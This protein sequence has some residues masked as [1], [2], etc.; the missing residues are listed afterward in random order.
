VS[1]KNAWILKRR[2][3]KNS[4]VRKVAIK[5]FKRIVSAVVNK[6]LQ[7]AKNR[8]KAK[9]SEDRQEAPS[10]ARPKKIDGI[11]VTPAIT[12]GNIV[13]EIN[14]KE[15]AALAR[16]YRLKKE[17]Q[18]DLIK[19]REVCEGKRKY[20][21]D[22]FRRIGRN[23][24]I[25]LGNLHRLEALESFKDGAKYLDFYRKTAIVSGGGASR[26]QSGV[27][28]RITTDPALAIIGVTDNGGA[29][30]LSRAFEV[31][32]NGTF[33]GGFGDHVRFMYEAAVLEGA[34]AAL[35]IKDILN[36]RFG[37][38]TKS[39]VE[40]LQDQYED[41]RESAEGSGTSDLKRFEEV[42]KELLEIAKIV[43]N[44]GVSCDYN[45]VK[46]MIFMGILHQT[47]GL[48][49]EFMNPDGI[50]AAF[51]M[52]RRLTGAKSMAIPD[53]SI[54]NEIAVE[55]LN[56]EVFIGQ[57]FYSHTPKGYD[58]GRD[59]SILKMKDIYNYYPSLAIRSRIMGVVSKA[60]L[61]LVGL[62]SW[63]T[64]I[65]IM[66]KNHFLVNAIRDN[67]TKDKILITNP[68]RDDETRGMSWRE[69]TVVFLKK[70]MGCPVWTV[71]R[72]I[73]ANNNTNMDRLILPARPSLGTA[74]QVFDGEFGGYGG[75]STAKRED[76]E[77]LERHGVKVAADLDMAEVKL[78][79]MWM[80]P[81]L[82]NANVAYMP[83]LFAEALWDLLSE[84]TKRELAPRPEV[85]L[86]MM[87]EDAPYEG[88][89]KWDYMEDGKAYRHDIEKTLRS[90]YSM[91]LLSLGIESVHELVF[92]PKLVKDLIANIDRGS[93]PKW[94]D[95]RNFADGDTAFQAILS[96]AILK[97]TDYK[98]HAELTSALALGK[99][100]SLKRSSIKLKFLDEKQTNRAFTK[101]RVALASK[102][103]VEALKKEEMH[104]LGIIRGPPSKG[105][106]SV[107]VEL[108][109]EITQLGFTPEERIQRMAVVIAFQLLK[110]EK[111]INKG[112]K[113][114]WRVHQQALKEFGHNVKGLAGEGRAYSF[115]E[116]PIYRTS[117]E[118]QELLRE[119]SIAVPTLRFLR[120]TLAKGKIPNIMFDM[121]GTFTPARTALPP[122]M[123]Y[124]AW[125]LFREL[126]ILKT[127]ITAQPY[128]GPQKQI[129]E[130]VLEIERRVRWAVKRS[131]I[132]LP[133]TFL[134]GILG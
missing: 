72:K 131:G 88:D 76:K 39:L 91:P 126:F 112:F 99:K 50:Y 35:I 130:Q 65:G 44:L 71:F 92:L 29:T 70:L 26:A 37:S 59:R 17:L 85:D 114:E 108:P 9:A 43:D 109:Y 15:K 115:Q 100:I 2:Y 19:L 16:L 104:R 34:P 24:H 1:N 69:S 78:T 128:E 56:G 64:S 77:E 54:G 42:F 122:E 74:R 73:L 5:A 33:V 60:K 51:E 49:Y 23:V 116:D 58:R 113:N 134:T 40:E 83:E 101:T 103:D 25:T 36:H 57:S 98:G 124:M 110:A 21:R 89:G 46:N 93:V 41:R 4:A 117:E 22:H 118:G 127:P 30:L 133:K 82:F 105:D 62:G 107:V 94:I 106:R 102:D 47:Q 13:S 52:F 61:L 120:R 90:K 53:D 63:A 45:S 79:P 119:V 87:G 11:Y 66:L 18:D 31:C 96:R 123:S 38:H 132:P 12:V 55:T 68:V 8:V 32:T 86:I 28:A 95:D 48:G 125:K 27:V 67:S 14:K 80:N 20:R 121:D 75:E 3:Y 6:K 97:G 7:E 111:L 84:E 129:I 10:K 81:D